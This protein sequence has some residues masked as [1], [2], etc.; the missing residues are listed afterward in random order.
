MSADAE[1][2]K[3]VETVVVALP[4]IKEGFAGGRVYGDDENPSGQKLLAADERADEILHD[5]LTELDGVGEYASEERADKVDCG[6]GVSVAVDPLDGSSNLVTNNLAGVIFGVYDAPLPCAGTELVGAGYAV[7]GPL[8]T[9]VVADGEN[10]TEYVV[11]EDE[12]GNG[13]RADARELS[14]PEPTV[15]GFGGGVENWTDGF[16]KF[17]YE[18]E[19]ELKLRYG[20]SMVGDVNQVM[21]KGGIFSYPALKERPDGKLRL[22]FEGAP[23]GYVVKTAGGASSDGEKSLLEREPDGIHDRTPVHVGNES[24]IER[25]EAS[26]PS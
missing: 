5:A 12:D 19:R 3:I 11:E 6:S 23:M 18:V 10:V 9:V 7:F 15:Y 21:H 22:L 24:L 14:L 20:G 16:V 8:T 4:R 1:F 17:A 25:L 2:D 26:L 13:E